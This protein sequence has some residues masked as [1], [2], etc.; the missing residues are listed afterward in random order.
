L[1]NLPPPV[2]DIQAPMMVRSDEEQLVGHELFKARSNLKVASVPPLSSSMVVH[3]E[4][5][6]SLYRQRM[7]Q[8]KSKKTRLKM[9]QNRLTKK[10]I[11]C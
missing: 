4:D 7:V 11:V 5:N 8:T 10:W 2:K 9:A 6:Q 3:S 1:G